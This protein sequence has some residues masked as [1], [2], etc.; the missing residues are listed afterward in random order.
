M[1]CTGAWV[2][3]ETVLVVL[4]V[5]SGE[6]V[7]EEEVRA[8]VLSETD[9][10]DSEVSIG[11]IRGRGEGEGSVEGLSGYGVLC[12]F[13]ILELGSVKELL[14]LVLKSFLLQDTF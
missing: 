9:V 6:V 8:D 3:L 10:Y 5:D 12:S 14:E 11:G 7:T 1:V 4:D 2:M 13:H